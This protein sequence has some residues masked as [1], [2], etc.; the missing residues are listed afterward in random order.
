MGDMTPIHLS[1]FQYHAIQQDL[2]DQHGMRSITQS[3]KKRELGWTPA[4]EHPQDPFDSRHKIR[5]D[6]WDPDAKSLFLLAY[7]DKISS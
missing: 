2:K 5:I 3:W 1:V 4:V 7:F 6:F